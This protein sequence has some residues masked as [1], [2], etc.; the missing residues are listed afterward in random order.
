MTDFPFTTLQLAWLTELRSGKHEQGNGY[1]HYGNEFC[2]LGIASK[3]VLKLKGVPNGAFTTYGGDA[4]GLL[5]PSQ[6]LMNLRS[7][8][9]RISQESL[10]V[11]GA[12]A[13]TGKSRLAIH[14]PSLAVMN[15]L[16]FTFPEIADFIE[17]NPRAVFNNEDK[18]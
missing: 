5:W 2:C 8:T 6:K 17:N 18:Q 4:F 7:S 14:R 10:S 11:E 16:G 3:F 9:G 12:R 1:L 13:L 15:D